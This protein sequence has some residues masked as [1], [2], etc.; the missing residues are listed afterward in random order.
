MLGVVFLFSVEVIIEAGTCP[1]VLTNTLF[2]WNSCV[3]RAVLCVC[4]RVY[5]LE[6]GSI[7][8]RSG[9]EKHQ[10]WRA[11]NKT[12]TTQLSPP[13]L[14]LSL[15]LTLAL[16]LSLSGKADQWRRERESRVIECQQEERSS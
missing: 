8:L 16:S 15:L 10:A 14:S 13:A 11:G 12:G 1:V 3:E 5:V 9:V 2:A 4:V 6:S 7:P